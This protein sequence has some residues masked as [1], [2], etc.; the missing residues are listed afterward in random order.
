MNK[1][2]KGF[3][4]V[5]ILSI[6]LCLFVLTGTFDAF[7]AISSGGKSSIGAAARVSTPSPTKTTVTPATQVAIKKVDA[8]VPTINKPQSGGA[9]SIASAAPKPVTA[10]PVTTSTPVNN[11]TASRPMQ[12]GPVASAPSTPRPQVVPVR[13]VTEVRTVYRNA[14]TTWVQP[15]YV[16]T[17]NSAYRDLYYQLA[18]INA[19]SNAAEAAEL[20][21]AM[22]ANPAYAGWQAEARQQA[23]ENAELRSELAAADKVKTGMGMGSIFL[24]ILAGCCIVGGIAFG[25]KRM[26]G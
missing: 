12:S 25:I 4:W 23:A 22:R 17:S 21:R 10:T 7:A 2:S 8:P 9:A 15:V 13:N 26:N 20:R 16:T 18:V 11:V 14:P 6:A 24:L 3:K 19:M 5:N 1:T